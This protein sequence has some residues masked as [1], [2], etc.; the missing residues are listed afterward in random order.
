MDNQDL[1]SFTSPNP[2]HKKDGQFRA[3]LESLSFDN[4]N[5]RVVM[6][7]KFKAVQN[8]F[9]NAPV[10]ENPP[11]PP[12][13]TVLPTVSPNGLVTYPH[14]TLP[15]LNQQS[16]FPVQN[17]QYQQNF[18][19]MP[20]TAYP[21]SFNPIPNQAFGQSGPIIQQQQQSVNIRQQQAASVPAGIRFNTN[22][23]VKSNTVQRSQSLTAGNSLGI[24]KSNSWNEDILT[25]TPKAPSLRHT[26]PPPS[27]SASSESSK[28]LSFKSKKDKDSLIDLGS[29]DEDAGN[30]TTV[31][32]LQDF[33][34]LN[35]SDEEEEEIYWSSTRSHFSESF[36][37]TNDPFSYM[38]QQAELTSRIEEV[39]DDSVDSPE[40]P[41]A[42]PRRMVGVVRPTSIA[43]EAT[44]YRRSM[45]ASNYENIVKKDRKIFETI[46]V[47]R[48]PARAL[49]GEV[50][51]FIEMVQ[52]VRRQYRHSDQET[53]PGL[54]T[55]VKLR[56]SYPPHTEMKLR[57]DST[58]FTA[59]VESELMVIIAQVLVK[60]EMDV[61][62]VGDYTLKIQGQSEYLVDGQLADYEYVHQCYKYD[63]DVHL[64][65]TH[66]TAVVRDVARTVSDDETDCDLSFEQISPLDTVKT[67]SYN[68]LQILLSTLQ[69][70]ADRMSVTARTLASCS[71]RE[72]MKALRPKQML[73]AVKAVAALLGG[74]ETLELREA[75]DQLCK[76]C[77]QVINNYY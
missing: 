68:S 75:C 10:S 61:G 74:V 28:K 36:Y 59:A 41:P 12:P 29:K 38:E 77:L 57:V 39:D 48:K 73:Q 65:L 8:L 56:A 42:V 35:E 76:S 6:Q 25:S 1:I 27:V 7:E 72:V 47:E 15:N 26:S 32:I 46:G 54:V 21:G 23:V 67:L 44:I 14:R 4:N 34:P 30:T 24:P 71:D 22:L 55:A 2:A 31:S 16:M 52:E 43:S 40:P 51:S 58:V 70:E 50:I 5:D 53:N 18:H 60:K 20:V 9:T 3:D 63:R 11:P 69:K 19:R 17:Q 37:D 49:D 13:R 66:N 33:D 64:S 45:T 62:L